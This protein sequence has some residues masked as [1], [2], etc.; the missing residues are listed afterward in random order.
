M[1]TFSNV[2][3]LFIYLFTYILLIIILEKLWLTQDRAIKPLCDRWP[4]QCTTLWAVVLPTEIWWPRI[5]SWQ[6]DLW[7]TQ[8]DNCLAFDPS[9]AGKHWSGIL[10]ATFSSH[11]AFLSKLIVGLTPADPWVTLHPRNVLCSGQGFL[12]PNYV[13]ISIG[14]SKADWRLADRWPLIGSLWKVAH[15]PR[16]PVPYLL[17]TPVKIKFQLSTSKHDKNA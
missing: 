7:L 5:I 1:G 8:D 9:N 3:C 16:G 15:K 2:S 17:P 12:W 10:L 4:H 13:A 6:I 11:G 14:I